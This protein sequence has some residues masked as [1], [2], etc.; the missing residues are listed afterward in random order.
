MKKL[1]ISMLLSFILIICTTMPVLAVDSNSVIITL[2]TFKVTIN[3]IVYDNAYNRY[4]L[5]V[6]KGVTY[7][8]MTYYDCRFLGLET[9]WEDIDRGLFVSTTGIS[10]SYNA[11]KQVSRNSQCYKVS[12]ASFP[13]T[14]NGTSIDNAAE[15]YPLLNFRDVTYFPM[16]WRF[17]VD[18][19]KWQYNFD[20]INGLVINSNNSK[21]KQLGA[22]PEQVTKEN[23]FSNVVITSKYVYYEATNGRI[24][25]ALLSNLNQ[26][27]AV[28]QLPI[29]NY[30]KD[31]CESSLIEKNDEVYLEYHQGDYLDGKDYYLRLMD[32]GRVIINEDNNKIFNYQ[33]ISFKYR[34]DKEPSVNNLYMK[35]PTKDTWQNIGN[36]DYIYGFNCATADCYGNYVTD[37]FYYDGEQYVYIIAFDSLNNELKSNKNGIYRINITTNE[38]IRLVSEDLDVTDFCY[39]NGYLY[40]HNEFVEFLRYNLTTGET[41]VI[42]PYLS[43]GN[44]YVNSFKVLNDTI[45]AT[46]STVANTLSLI[47]STS[48]IMSQQENNW[49]A[50]V[51]SLELKGNNNEYLVCTF[52]E[53]Q[54]SNYRLMVF[55]N[56]SNIILKTA[57]KS[58][59][60]S[61]KI[62][63]KKLYFYN[64][65]T[66]TVCSYEL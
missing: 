54:Y 28:F 65:T 36:Y 10:G 18:E 12:Y 45:Y 2:P 41:D 39:D 26:T 22:L 11:F 43:R 44:N 55:D 61:V 63:G 14:V 49:R 20:S 48:G 24:M 3:D 40:Y 34:V 66:K 37:C 27:K 25:Q 50:T 57:D 38:T 51:D 31:Y 35:Y 47:N 32:D 8:P 9:A 17:C 60:K 15:E 30:L 52:V 56:T 64:Y 33:N 7:F 23:R 19:F 42:P 16:T 6:Y 59:A 62:V 13:I 46:S 1:F 58:K 4:P 53:S 29:N 21:I 5:I